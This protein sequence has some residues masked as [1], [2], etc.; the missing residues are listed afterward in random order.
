VPVQ[1]F[2]HRIASS[3]RLIPQPHPTPFHPLPPLPLPPLVRV[4]G[5][6]YGAYSSF[7]ALKGGDGGR[8]GYDPAAGER[9]L[10]FWAVLSFLFIYEAFGEWLLAFLVPFYT[11]LKCVGLVWLLIPGSDAPRYF[12]DR[13]LHPAVTGGTAWVHTRLLPA[14]ASIAVRAATLLQP[15]V[16]SAVS[17]NLLK[18]ELH[19]W[20]R[21]L[22]SQLLG[23]SIEL[24]RRRMRGGDRET[25]RL[26]A[27]RP[28]DDAAAALVDDAAA[29]DKLIAEATGGSPIH[30][31]AI[32]S[33]A[34]AFAE[35][36]VFL[37]RGAFDNDDDTGGG[38]GGGGGASG[39][40]GA[41]PVPTPT[42]ATAT[43]QLQQYAPA[44]VMTTP[45]PAV[46]SRPS[47]PPS[48]MAVPPTPAPP[49]LSVRFAASTKTGGDEEYDDGAA[50]GAEEGDPTAAEAAAKSHITARRGKRSGVGAAAGRVRG[51]LGRW[52]PRRGRWPFRR[53]PGSRM[54]QQRRCSRP[55]GAPRRR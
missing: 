28:D 24:E 39:V 16:F 21:S 6:F 15:R 31:G 33:F 34:R 27:E 51:G 55:R 29:R 49:P 5:L 50:G 19:A 3:S 26:L 40:G 54:R 4:A 46:S 35:P 23:A 25:D 41:P 53:P 37:G 10:R 44:G 9:L 43:V 11:E 14:V 18:E 36:P 17:R 8:G 47:A 42:P 45:P 48:A 2:P 20:D 13:F 7:K 12:F 30:P 52:R 22:R 38:V 32:R 1:A